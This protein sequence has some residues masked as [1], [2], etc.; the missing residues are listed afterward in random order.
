[1]AELT[2]KSPAQGL[3]PLD[4]AGAH[5]TEAEAAPI[6]SLAPYRGQ[7][8]ALSAALN[9]SL[10][11]GFPDPGKLIA[12]GGARI[13]WSGR[14]QAFLMGARPNAGLARHGAIVDQS[15]AWAHLVLEGPGARAVLARL[16]PIDLAPAACPPASA[17]R[18][19]L[20]HMPML[21]LHP[22]GDRF[23]ILVFRS[24]AG[25]AIHELEQVMRMLAARAAA[26]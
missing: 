22:G 24:M 5:L 19:L 18:T 8:G 23:E 7:A 15:D 9:A 26:L 21:L 25:T 16:V 12:Q 20:G 13:A 4:I 6:W 2:P 14:D 3:K 17:L 10:G 11:L 1:M